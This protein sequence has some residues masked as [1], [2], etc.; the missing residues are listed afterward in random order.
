MQRSFNES[1]KDR[2][3]DGNDPEWEELRSELFLVLMSYGQQI[4]DLYQSIA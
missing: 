2:E 3:V 4:R 1:I